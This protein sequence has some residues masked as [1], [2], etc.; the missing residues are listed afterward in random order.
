MAIVDRTKLLARPEVK[1]AISQVRRALRSALSGESF[2]EREVEALTISGEAVRELL[3]EDLQ[4][5][6]DSFGD[7]VLVDGVR[8]SLHEPGS[9]T[10]HCL[11]GPLEI[12]RP[13][14]RQMGVRNG[15]IVVAVELAAGLVEGA[16]PRWPTAWRTATRSTTCAR[17]RR[18]W[19][20][21]TGCRLRARRWSESP[22]A[23]Q[24]PRSRGPRRSSRWCGAPSACPKEPSP[25]RSGWTAR[26]CR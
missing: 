19:R 11:C 10:Y 5:I 9:D 21:L 8:Y 23:W 25:S 26:R 2:G 22:R 4:A 18:T 14:H 13:T 3:R 7:E 16:T 24:A 17:T 1:K 12:K 15:P 20:P 6:A